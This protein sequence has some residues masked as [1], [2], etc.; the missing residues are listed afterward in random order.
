MTRR[1]LRAVVIGLV[2]GNLMFHA[3]RLI[4]WIWRWV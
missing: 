3:V 1:E 2:L 4:E